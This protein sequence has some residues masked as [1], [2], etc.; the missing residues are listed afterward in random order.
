MI[1]IPRC[2]Y[3]IDGEKEIIS[4]TLV[5]EALQR[6]DTSMLEKLCPES[7]IKYLTENKIL[8]R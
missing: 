8:I 4:A 5:R 2:T 6:K 3:D 7:T 1:E